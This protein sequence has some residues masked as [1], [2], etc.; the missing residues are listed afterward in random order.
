VFGGLGAH[1]V[2]F[3]VAVN[4]LRASDEAEHSGRDL[5]VGA[6][7]DFPVLTDKKNQR[8]HMGLH[9]LQT[10]K[11]WLCSAGFSSHDPYLEQFPAKK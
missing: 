1:E 11:D 4:S 2:F 9:C 5:A 10:Y 7:Y 3:A 6:G 8:M